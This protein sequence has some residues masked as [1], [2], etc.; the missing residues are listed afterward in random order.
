MFE[1]DRNH[2]LNKYA[3]IE[4]QKSWFWRMIGK[5][6]DPAEDEGKRNFPM[7]FRTVSK[8]ELKVLTK[9]RNTK[10]MQQQF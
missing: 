6:L 8:E 5:K 2:K 9:D 1:G 7:M 3:P 4:R 10:K